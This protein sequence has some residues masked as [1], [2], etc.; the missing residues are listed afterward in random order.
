MPKVNFNCA[1][2][3]ITKAIERW[4]SKKRKFCSKKCSDDSNIGKKRPIETG[5]KIRA[6]KI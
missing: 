2:C 6:A 5:I 4:E 1:M 3:G